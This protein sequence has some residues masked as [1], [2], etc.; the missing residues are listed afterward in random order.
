[1]LKSG[2]HSRSPE[3]NEGDVNIVVFGGGCGGGGGTEANITLGTGVLDGIRLNGGETGNGFK[4]G[5]AGGESVKVSVA[6]SS[7]KSIEI[8]DRTP[9]GGL[10]GD[11]LTELGRTERAG[12]FVEGG[13]LINY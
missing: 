2:L 1:L 8:S 3:L 10:K 4:S 13:H 5:G 6:E 7:K 9:S 11:S 12:V